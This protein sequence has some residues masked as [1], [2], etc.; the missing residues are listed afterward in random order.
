MLVEFCDKNK[1]VII[2]IFFKKLREAVHM[3]NTGRSKS[4]AVGLHK[5]EASFKKQY[6]GCADRY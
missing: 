4:T 3:K 6:E 5:C 2:N 1:L